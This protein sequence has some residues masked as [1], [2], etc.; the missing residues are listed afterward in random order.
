MNRINKNKKLTTEEIGII[1]QLYKTN[2]YSQVEIAK[3]LGISRNTVYLW[4][5]RYNEN[6][7]VE[8]RPC[9][10]IEQNN[11]ISR[12]FSCALWIIIIVVLFGVGL[13]LRILF[14][15]SVR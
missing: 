11:N 10:A 2:C 4:V 14:D 3:M 7:N 1:I 8:Q 9:A 5:K 15:E 6:N 13:T 12:C